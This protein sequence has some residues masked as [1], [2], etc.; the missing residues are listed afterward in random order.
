M[1]NLSLP[2]A[3]TRALVTGGASGIG[4]ACAL[5]LAAR[6]A[7]V[8]VLDLVTDGV[9]VPLCAH[10]GDVA[11]DGVAAVVDAVAGDSGLD[12]VVNSAGVGA[13]GTFADHDLD[14]WR[15]VLDVNL[16]GIVRVCT[17]A[18]PALRR[19]SRASIVNI[20]SVAA[21]Q[22]L[23][24]RAVYS[25]SKGAVAALTRSMAADLVGEGIRVNAVSP[26]TVDTPW[27]QRLLDRA[28]DRTAALAALE[29][30]QPTGRLV[31][32]TEVAQAVAYLADPR[33]PS[34]HG[35]ILSVDGGLQHLK[36][37]S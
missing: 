22:G 10:R 25:A 37:R 16:L 26:G 29:A 13:V 31:G 17:A 18:L 15:H 23:P 30:R 5:E 8:H 27:V 12:V 34:V 24:Q 9:A 35:T 6:G 7:E 32:P 1:T 19:S 2:L 11:D 28:G 3:G 4:L 21:T 36:G 14:E 33:S 20:C